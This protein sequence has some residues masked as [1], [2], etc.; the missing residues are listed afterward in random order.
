MVQLQFPGIH[1]LL[2]ATSLDN[3]LSYKKG[4]IILNKSA[5]V[6]TTRTIAVCNLEDLF[7]SS[8]KDEEVQKKV[9]E[10]LNY[11]EGKVFPI[12]YWEEL[13]KKSLI[14][15]NQDE[16]VLFIKGSGYEKNLYNYLE[17]FNVIDVINILKTIQFKNPPES[18][19]ANYYMD[20]QFIK[21]FVSAFSNVLKIDKL[22]VDQTSS[23]YTIKALEHEIFFAIAKDEEIEYWEI[24]SNI[25][26]F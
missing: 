10:I 13:T 11:M 16:D 7:L 6:I 23:Y 14:E 20:F 21:Q 25:N 26:T 15:Y 19:E 4:V 3:N 9:Y 1:K 5:V 12:S 8:E 2:P 24:D 17:G 18:K 22:K